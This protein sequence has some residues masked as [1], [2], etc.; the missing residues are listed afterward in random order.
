GTNGTLRVDTPAG[1]RTVTLVRDR[2]GAVIAADVDMGTATFVPAEI[3]FSEPVVR[4]V[5]AKVDGV[6][7]DGD[8]VGMGNPH[9]VLRVDDVDSIPVAIHGPVLEHDPRFP[10]RTNVE[11]VAVRDRTHARMRVWERGAGETLSCG[12]GAC[13]AAAALHARGLIDERVTMRVD[14]GD[15]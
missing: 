8:A 9:W 10:Q 7:Y 15:L 12:T 14:G 6:G 2:D 5:V 13:A 3:P 1:P 4:D 11:W